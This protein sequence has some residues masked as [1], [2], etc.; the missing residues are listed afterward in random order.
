MAAAV[1][2]LV[3]VDMKGAPP[4]ARH[5]ADLMPWLARWGATGVLIEWEDMLPWSGS[6][7]CARHPEAYTRDEVRDG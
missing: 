3:H 4:T 6:L 1:E 2:V 7:E 5:L